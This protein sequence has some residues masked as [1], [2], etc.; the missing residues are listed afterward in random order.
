MQIFILFIRNKFV[1]TPKGVPENSSIIFVCY[2][3]DRMSY[4]KVHTYTGE[5]TIPFSPEN[6]LLQ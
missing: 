6:V 5:G 2:E 1:V 3:N 4:V